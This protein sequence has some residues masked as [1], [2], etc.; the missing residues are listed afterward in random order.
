MLAERIEVYEKYKKDKDS[1]Y[2]HKYKTEK[3][4]KEM[5]PFL[6][7]ASS[8][9]LQQSRIDLDSAYKNFFKRIKKGK[10]G[11]EVGFPKFKKKACSKW[12]YREPQ[13]NNIAI[14]IKG[15]RLKLNKLGWLKF[16][17]LN[18]SVS[19]KIKSVTIELGRDN[20][21][22]AAILYEIPETR[23]RKRKDNKFIGLDLGL[24]EFA[25]TS[26]GEFIQG[27]HKYLTSIDSKIN[28]A[29]KYLSRKNQGSNRYNK[30]RIKLNRIYKKR[31]NIQQHFFWHLANK[32]CSENQAISIENLNVKGMKSNRKLSKA[33]H[34]VS[35]S[36]FPNML[37]QKAV[38]YNTTIHEVE[39]FFPSSKLCSCCGN[40][41]NDLKL[42][43]RNYTC[44]CGYT[45][46][47]DINAAINLRNEFFKNTST[48]YVDYKRGET[49]RPKQIIYNL[50]G[51][52]SEAFT[53]ELG[54]CA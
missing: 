8:R 35:W 41:K 15:N 2:A 30:Q 25:T 32:L 50:S 39:R 43:D 7:D 14:E 23:K 6:K 40:L 1:L 26:A 19:G 27:I 20:K 12:S 16:R 29:N 4:Y 24:K 5:Y 11:R 10:K 53:D 49:V 3:E 42:S 54:K 9:A 38:E 18:K 22:Y 28:K 48:E 51:S 33:I 17:G 31:S 13:V 45:Q 21:Y 46:D 44:D 52:F 34:H 36:K 47:R 37:K